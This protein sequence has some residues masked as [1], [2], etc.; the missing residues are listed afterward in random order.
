MSPSGLGVTSGT[1]G[2]VGIS[3][4]GWLGVVT[5]AD[6]TG[7]ST[8]PGKPKSGL[9]AGVVGVVDSTGAG[10]VGVVGST[11]AVGGI[12]PGAG[13]GTVAATCAAPPPELNTAATVATA[14]AAPPMAAI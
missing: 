9:G 14:A 6:V 11:G 3:I 5:G 7:G 13:G 1:L 10:V 4:A 2:A 8:G 12:S